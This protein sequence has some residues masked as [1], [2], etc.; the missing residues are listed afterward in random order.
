[1]ADDDDRKFVQPPPGFV[2]L[3][4]SELWVEGRHDRWVVRGVL[5]GRSVIRD[6]L[7]SHAAAC[8]AGWLLWD[9]VRALGREPEFVDVTKVDQVVAEA[10]A[11]KHA[12]KR[13]QKVDPPGMPEAL[14]V[15]V[16]SWAMMTGAILF[17]I[18]D[19]AGSIRKA[20]KVIGVPKSTV[21]AWVKR[22]RERGTWPE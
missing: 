9:D 12:V 11:R 16:D 5:E 8:R 1:M 14:V 10:L 6:G 7:K 17:K 21:T 15:V 20:A 3:R 18:V 13:E 19:G 22:H 2:V 4:E